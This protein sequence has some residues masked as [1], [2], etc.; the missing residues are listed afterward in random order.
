MRVAPLDE[1]N[2]AGLQALFAAAHSSCYC[3]WWHFGGTKNEWLDRCAHRPEENAA[4]QA[5]AVRAGEAGARGL[6]AIDDAGAVVGWLKLT[7][8]SAVR[9]LRSLP[10]Y[11]SLDLGD[12]ETTWSIGCLL[13]RPDRRR[14]GV[15]RALVL[16]APAFVRAGGGRAIE[17]YPRRA[18][19]PLS[20]EEAWHGH[21]AMYRAA[22]FEVVHDEPPYPVLRRSTQSA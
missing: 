16:A 21:E 1:T 22:G 7:P 9:K 18:D 6:V 20:D 13:V 19:Y 4:E 5:A 15:A 12:E 2:L 11:R 3:R 17:A 8:R 10:V 14:H